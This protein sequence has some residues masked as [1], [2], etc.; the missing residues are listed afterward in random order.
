MDNYTQTAIASPRIQYTADGVQTVFTY[1]FPIFKDTDID[2]YEDA[3]L[4]TMTTDYTVVGAGNVSGGTITF[5]TPPANGVVV[6]LRRNLTIQR[7]SD[8][9]VP[10]DFRAKLINYELDHHTAVLQQIS[11]GQ[12]QSLQYTTVTTL[13]AGTHNIEIANNR[14]YYVLD[15]SGGAI[16]VNLPAIGAD[17][18]IL[19]GFQ[20]SGTGH[21]ATIVRDG[22][23]QINGAAANYVLSA[24]T[25]VV[26]FIADDNTPDNWIANVQSQ[27]LAGDGLSKSGST[28]SLDRTVAGVWSGSQRSPFVVDNDGSFDCN[29]GHHFKCTPTSA[30]TLQFTNEADGQSGIIRLDNSGG[31]VVTLG[32]ECEAD[33]DCETNLST[34]GVYL[35]GYITDGTTVSLSYSGGLV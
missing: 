26:E 14:T 8:Y 1:P 30:I 2:V 22:T 28:M 23:D 9:L 35:V 32:A 24:D 6:T 12:G 7:T 31:Y 18:G 19:F 34:A 20:Q 4:K 15:V 16:T 17:E 27:T 25:E 13:T 11:D 5:V 3:T 29:L 33:A 10:D 21:A